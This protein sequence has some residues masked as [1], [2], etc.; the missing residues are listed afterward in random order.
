[1]RPFFERICDRLR[2]LI[3]VET[4]RLFGLVFSL[5][6]LFQVNQD[7]F[8][9]PELTELFEDDYDKDSETGVILDPTFDR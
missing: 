9:N 5:L 8:T 4:T 3:F 7:P 6:W 1:M 2:P